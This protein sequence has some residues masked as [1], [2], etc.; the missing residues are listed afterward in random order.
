MKK[1]IIFFILVIAGIT[2]NAQY[3]KVNREV[4][5]PSE[6]A[7]LYTDTLVNAVNIGD[8]ICYKNTIDTILIVTVS[9]WTDYYEGDGYTP[10]SVVFFVDSTGQHGWAAGLNITTSEFYVG[11]GLNSDIYVNFPS[12]FAST[13]L[14]LRDINGLA[15]T[16][17]IRSGPNFS[18]DDNPAIPDSPFYLPAL[19]QLLY[20]YTQ[21][22]TIKPSY[23][24]LEIS[25]PCIS[26][27]NRFWTSTGHLNEDE[28]D[29][30]WVFN[31]PTFSTTPIIEYNID[32]YYVL[33]VMNF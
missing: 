13:H 20:F 32:Y 24:T 25:L 17:S 11:Q 4:I 15:N 7:A 14:A 8:I 16:N 22:F 3:I 12:Y 30:V 28:Y 10:L 27:N 1:I 23:D 6:Y 9:D 26:T 29:E 5:C 2:V 21:Y 33:P 31:L 19:G 18:T